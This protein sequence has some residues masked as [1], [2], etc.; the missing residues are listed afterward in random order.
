MLFKV[1]I[2]IIAILVIIIILKNI[3]LIH[4]RF[5]NALAGSCWLLA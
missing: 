2:T 1:I 4:S 5:P 3:I